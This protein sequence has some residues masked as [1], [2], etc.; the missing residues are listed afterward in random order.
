VDEQPFRLLV[1]SVRE[2]AIFLL[3]NDGRIV[4]WNAGAQRLKGYSAAE[5]VGRHVSVFYPP[6]TP[7]ES[8]EAN[9]A[10]AT[11]EGQFRGEGW[12]VRKDGSRFLADVTITA[13][14]SPD[15]APY[16]FAKV[17]KDVTAERQRTEAL[18]QL[19]SSLD[20]SQ[21]IAHI[22]SWE[23][24]RATERVWWSAEMQRIYGFEPGGFEG[25]FDAFL[26][27]V[28][29]ADRDRVQAVV[30]DA[31]TSGR[32]FAFEHRIV[33]TDDEE[34]VL[35]A[36]GR[37]VLDEAGRVVKMI[38][39]GQDVTELKR[40]EEARREAEE[41]GRRDAVAREGEERFRIMA[42]TAPVMVWMAG[43]GKV[44]D[45]FNRPWLE[46]TGRTMEQALGL[47]WAEGVHRDDLQRCLETYAT[48]FDRHEPFRKEYRLRRADGE[49]RWVL[50]TGTPRI[51]PEGFLGYVGSCIDITERREAEAARERHLAEAR[52]AWDRAE[53]ASRLK[54][55]FLAVLSHELRTPLNA[56]VGWAAMLRMAELDEATRTK[57]VETI[58]RNAQ[59]QSQLIADVLDISRIVAGKLRLH[60][61][62][63]DLVRIVEDA[64]DTV[65]PAAEARQIAIEL[66]L[67][68]EAGPVWGD[69]DR[70]QQ[71]VWNLLTNAIKF[72]PPGGH[73]EVRLDRRGESVECLVQDDGPGVD[74]DFLPFVFD[75]FRQADS[76]SS[77]RH[78]GLGLGLAISRSLVEQHGGRI[79]AT[80]RTNG[81]GAVFGFEMPSSIHGHAPAVPDSRAPASDESEAGL[82]PLP[83]LAGVHALVVDDDADSLAL[84]REV[85][86]RAGATAVTAR[87]A[88]E[89]LAAVAG[90]RF[91]VIVSDVEM[92]GED[93]YS[94]V[95]RLRA[96]ASSAGGQTPAVA[97]TA[98]A[99]AEDRRNA[100]LAGFQTHVPKPVDPAELLAVVAS[101]V[102]RLTR[103]GL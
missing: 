47:G 102:G 7:R 33:R 62:P 67:A 85:L 3:D 42:D 63:V 45:W 10:H 37:V 75:R 99:R 71:V 88:A 96:L 100:L 4:S 76:S 34:R 51:G 56:I 55:E 74:P 49:Y 73:V 101:L 72:T 69:S 39:T 28:H 44:C 64:A 21:A 24:D 95:R 52:G 84:A 14:R 78:G 35:A 40:A 91:D 6:G 22:G 103:T 57:A 50:D 82:D 23:W 19:A 31:L 32:P 9:L 27:R 5:I 87:S 17:T 81:H 90:R 41:R 68:P 83:S 8:V 26:A 12:R 46:F 61:K 1:D 97:L 98:Y 66:R 30:A 53:Q 54:D 20:E 79:W 13:L 25:G 60:P 77:R 59:L 92:P 70:L 86:E 2:Y 18:V 48:A 65:R 89:A 11:R 93:G 29:P 94:M 80:N 38:G 43:R 15:G 16:G 58:H 36:Q